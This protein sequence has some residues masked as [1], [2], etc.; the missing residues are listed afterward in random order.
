MTTTEIVLFSTCIGASAAILSQL[1][2]N[3]LKDKS[4][5]RKVKIG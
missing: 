4:E 3:T 2:A 5:N 1:V